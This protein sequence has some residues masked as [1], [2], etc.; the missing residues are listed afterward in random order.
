M[1]SA[2]EDE[3]EIL[4]RR[5]KKNKGKELRGGGTCF[6]N[7]LSVQLEQNAWKD[8]VEDKLRKSMWVGQIG[9]KGHPKTILFSSLNIS[10]T[11]KGR[12]N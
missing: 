5:K 9:L 1:I 2:E 6:R 3:T 11:P 7:P 12:T 4:G 8:L 10:L